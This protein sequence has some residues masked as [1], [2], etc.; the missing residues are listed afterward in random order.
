M[1]L[2]GLMENEK[3]N[4][5]VKIV[6]KF[7]FN[8]TLKRMSCIAK[9]FNGKNETSA[10]Y[11]VAT[12]GAPE[13]LA[14]RFSNKPS[15]YTD[16]YKSYARQGSRVLSLGMK[17]IG[18][19]KEYDRDEVEKDLEFAGFLVFHC[20]IKHDSKEAIEKLL[21]SSHRVIMITGDNPLTACHVAKE[22]SMCNESI[23]ILD[24]SDDNGKARYSINNHVY[25][26]FI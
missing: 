23:L 12:K 10:K 21:Y 8:S 14:D 15:W 17:P 4:V 7:E 1:I 25:Q 18:L 11:F 6:K 24:G 9:R 20:P 13:V 19:A 3:Q 22:V 5:S 16:V 26:D 2:D